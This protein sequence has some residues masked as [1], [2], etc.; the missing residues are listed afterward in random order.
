MSD[1]NASENDEEEVTDSEMTN[2]SKPFPQWTQPRNLLE[3]EK[4][5]FKLLNDQTEFI[6]SENELNFNDVFKKNV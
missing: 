5:Q 6:K 2:M 3:L 4:Q 1:L